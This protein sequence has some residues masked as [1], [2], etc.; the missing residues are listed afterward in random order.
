[1]IWHFI[2]VVRKIIWGSLRRFQKAEI[3]YF[4]TKINLVN[5]NFVDFSNNF[6]CSDYT[7]NL[8]QIKIFQFF[9]FS[10]S[11]QMLIKIIFVAKYD[12]SAFWIR[13]QHDSRILQIV[14][15]SLKSLAIIFCDTHNLVNT[16]GP[17][18][19]IFLLRNILEIL[20]TQ[21]F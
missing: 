11:Q 1:M 19:A 8:A 14:D 6:S 2:K 15:T 10:L 13:I 18:D 3:W 5:I 4:S 12:I 17:H 20:K 7:W 9:N 16:C 21:H